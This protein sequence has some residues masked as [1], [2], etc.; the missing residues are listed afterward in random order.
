MRK[1]AA[2]GQVRTARYWLL[3]AALPLASGA[4][5]IVHVLTTIS[6]GLALVGAGIIVIGVGTLTWMRLPSIARTEIVQRA[7][8]GL[9]AGFLATIAYDVSRWLIVTLFHDTFAP[10]DVFPIFGHAIAGTNLS[11]AVATTIGILYHYTNG[12][13]FAVAYAIL[14][15]PRAWWTGILWALGLEALMLTVYPGWLHPAPFE[16][17]VSVSILGHVAYGSVLG[18][19]S[20]RLLARQRRTHVSGISL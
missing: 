1:G 4:A 17:F 13:L 5:L 10:F 20:R 12:V 6:L 8:V 3:L 19:F 7:K 9:I 18:I 15:A 16:E 14:L 2:N 11:P